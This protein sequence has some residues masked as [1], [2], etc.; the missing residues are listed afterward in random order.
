MH[1]KQSMTRCL[2]SAV[3]SIPMIFTISAIA[4]AE[5]VS[6]KLYNDTSSRLVEFYVSPSELDDWE[7]NLIPAGESVPP[8]GSGTV[9]IRDG[10]TVCEYDIWGVFSNGSEVDDYDID[11]CELES[12]TFF[13]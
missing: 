1:L 12:Y 10:R 2:G 13:E 9:D 7:E 8:G 11:V 4:L 6:F 5:D 3:L